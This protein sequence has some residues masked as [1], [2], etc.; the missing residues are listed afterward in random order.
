MLSIEEEKAINQTSLLGV[1]GLTIETRPDYVTDKA[2]IEYLEYGVT[3]VQLGGQSTHDDILLKIK[4]GCT[5]KNMKQALRRLKGVG[6]KVV[7]HWMP[8]L[9]GSSPQLDNMG[10]FKFSENVL[11]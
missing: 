9:P 2:L 5:K 6:L 8:D 10:L 3:R 4:R 1:I 11:K 7:T